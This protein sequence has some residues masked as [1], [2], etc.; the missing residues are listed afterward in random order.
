MIGTVSLA[1]TFK[2]LTLKI[3]QRQ[4]IFF[5]L[6]PTK[7]TVSYISNSLQSYNVCDHQ[8]LLNEAINSCIL[9]DNFGDYNRWAINADGKF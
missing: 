1:V 3:S 6:F 9:D 2:S 4:P 8:L 5:S 7:F